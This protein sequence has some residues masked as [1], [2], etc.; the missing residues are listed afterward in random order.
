MDRIKSYICVFWKLLKTD[1]VIFTDNLVG[2]WVDTVIWFIPMA[3]I[4]TYIFPQFGM[5]E[6]F[7]PFF[8]SG[9]LVT[10]G[11]FNIWSAA[12][13]FV[14]DLTGD[15]TI[16]QE[17][18]LPIPS[19]LVIVQ[20]ALSYAIRCACVVMVIVPLGSLMLFNRI[21]WGN[22]LVFKLCVIFIASMMFLGAFFVFVAGLPKNMHQLGRIGM[23]VLV[24][25]WFISGTQYPFQ[26]IQKMVPTWGNLL[27]VSPLLYAQEGVHGAFLGQTGFLSFWLCLGMLI[28][29]IILF[30]WLGI[31]RLQKRLDFCIR[32]VLQHESAY[33]YE[34]I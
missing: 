22:I 27:L 19:W 30:I 28:F 31:R 9:L 2:E 26:M 33:T 25:I 32:G 1:W 10:R 23:R 7:G 12:G 5:T 18:I 13:A 14:A 8:A 15:K 11:F 4:A 6:N 24:P 17:L 3:G 29:F 34:S 21:A 20:K 16:S